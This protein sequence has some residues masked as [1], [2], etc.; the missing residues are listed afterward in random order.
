MQPN[1]DA[2]Q[3]PID[4]FRK[5]AVEFSTT[6]R[7]DG[8]VLLARPRV[9]L[10]LATLLVSAAVVLLLFAAGAS[11]ARRVEG[12]AS[13]V[14]VPGLVE[15]LSPMSGAIFINA[16]EGSTVAK[17]DKLFTVQAFT[18]TT[19]AADSSARISTLILEK[20][21]SLRTEVRRVQSVTG[22][23]IADLRLRESALLHELKALQEQ[24]HL[25]DERLVIAENAVKK[26]R[27]LAQ[28]NFMGL[29]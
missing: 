15:L 11:T 10:S 24:E 1:S 21:E 28:S 27:E 20:M 5:E 7:F 12:S 4:L 3:V 29:C 17:G 2:S 23:K 8:P 19:T 18:G 14:S 9:L 13:V 26:H 22:R 16:V 6:R 25:Q